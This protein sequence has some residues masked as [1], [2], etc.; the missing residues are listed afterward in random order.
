MLTKKI[1]NCHFEEKEGDIEGLFYNEIGLQADK[2][3]AT[4]RSK[5]S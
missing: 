3:I 4:I 2:L 1:W 5:F